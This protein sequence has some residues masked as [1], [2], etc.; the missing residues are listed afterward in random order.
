MPVAGHMKSI[1]TRLAVWYALAATTTL[2]CLFAAGYF[3][4]KNHLIHG[5][6]ML[7]TSQ[8]G[9]IKSH[10]MR[11][12]D[13]KDPT[14]LE[15][16][17]RKSVERV[18]AHFF[19]DIRNPLTEVTFRSKNLKG[20]VLE[21]SRNEHFYNVNLDGIGSLRVGEFKITPLTIR[22]ATPAG[23][24]E[25]V[26]DAYS[27]ICL[28]LLF[29]MML[30]SLAIG[31]V[32]S[33][34]ALRPVRLIS[35]TANRIRSDNLNER[36]P[37]ANVQDEVSDL[38]RML[39]QM[40]DRLESSF[41]QIRQF[42]AEASHELKTPITLVRLYA[43]KMLSEGALSPE[44]EEAVL[45]Q[46]EEL[47]RLDQII[48]E[49][50]FLSRAEANAI[51]LNLQ[52]ANPAGFLQNFAHDAH[53][54]AGHQGRLFAHTHDGEGK[55]A[56]DDKRVRQVLLNLLTNALKV[57]PPGGRI[58]LRSILENDLWR[59]SVED[60][61]P[62]LPESEHERIFERFVRIRPQNASDDKGSGL[63][64]AICRSIIE[65]HRGRIFA[66]VGAEGRGL[67]IVIEIPATA[68]C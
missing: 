41:K 49:L 1:S 28:A 52:S 62:G 21:N 13:P 65:L 18:N 26:L 16:R 50:L 54:L 29:S 7:D 20:Q 11:E 68:F 61:G 55:I 27:K 59:I 60:E 23:E 34:L 32:L 6:D 19:V 56:F 57:T 15:R 38:A 47:S 5:L 40:F 3:L 30:A 14:L 8:F 42:S 2:A 37:I 9:D 39:N 51:T 67:H 22:V 36:I 4:L 17:L 35:E 24:A 12:F 66:T 31:F 46:L 58:T 43:E 44:N 45:I 33:R 48:E 64:L 25:N 10:L 53:V 63:G